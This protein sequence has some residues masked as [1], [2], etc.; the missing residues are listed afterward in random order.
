MHSTTYLHPEVVNVVATSLYREWKDLYKLCNIDLELLK[1]NL[2]KQPTEQLP[3]QLVFYQGT[4]LVA[5][6]G[7]DI[8]PD[9]DGTTATLGQP[10]ITSVYVFP[11]Y[12]GRGLAKKLIGISINLITRMGYQELYLWTDN[13]TR[14]Y[15]S[16]GF[17]LIES[18]REYGSRSVDILKK[19]IDRTICDYTVPLDHPISDIFPDYL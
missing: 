5:T 11:E 10:W 13:L 6:L 19:T 3:I 15:Q 4:Q 9:I 8:E 1:Q 2:R 7:L 16:M 14:V 17:K 18:G 12:R